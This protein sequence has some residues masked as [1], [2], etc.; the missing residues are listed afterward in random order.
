MRKQRPL[1]V[2][3]LAILLALIVIFAYGLRPANGALKSGDWLGFLGSVLVFIG[4]MFVA[5]VAL[6]QN[7][8]FVLAHEGYE[9]TMVGHSKGGAEAMCNA[10]VTGTNCITFNPYPIDVDHYCTS[11]AVTSYKLSG[12]KMTHYVVR[13]EVLNTIFGAPSV[14]NTFYL[15]TMYYENVQMKVLP[16]WTITWYSGPDLGKNHG[17]D[18]VRWGLL[19]ARIDRWT[20]WD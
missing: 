3:F 16:W 12:A 10:I 13:G 14:G 5:T 15:K 1:I 2:L 17:L 7:K 8:P 6:R 20:F 18:A 11:E 4:S 9:V 19:Q